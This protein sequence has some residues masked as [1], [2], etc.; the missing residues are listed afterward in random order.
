MY[1]IEWEFGK[2]TS[3]KQPSKCGTAILSTKSC[4]LKFLIPLLASKAMLTK[5]Y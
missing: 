4:F 1:I 3:E 5:S 2:M